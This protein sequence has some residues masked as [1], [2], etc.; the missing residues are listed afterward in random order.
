VFSLA[1]GASA[2]SAVPRLVSPSV[3]G[4]LSE[5]MDGA[6]D[7]AG[8]DVAGRIEAVMVKRCAACVCVC[9][10]VAD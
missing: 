10:W 7:M 5:A 1:S 3:G 4:G 2:V 9:V 8:H 6:A